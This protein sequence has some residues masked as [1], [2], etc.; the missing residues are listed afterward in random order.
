MTTEN[1]KR[2]QIAIA[3]APHISS[4]FWDLFYVSLVFKR[5]NNQ[6][7]HCH[8]A[9]RPKSTGMHTTSK[10]HPHTKYSMTYSYSPRLSQTIAVALCNT[11]SILYHKST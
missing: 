9:L 11:D 8:C 5:G 7:R 3:I 4:L 2:H 1:K 6:K 10:L